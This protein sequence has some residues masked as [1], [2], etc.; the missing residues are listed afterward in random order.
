RSPF[1]PRELV[2]RLNAVLRR[3]RGDVASSGAPVMRRGPLE[4]SMAD[5]TVRKNGQVIR[6]SSREFALLATL[7]QSTGHPLSRAQ[8]IDRAFGRD[9]EVTDRAIDVQITRLRRA[10]GERGDDTGMIRT[11]RGVGYMFCGTDD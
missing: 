11:V 1:L 7:A 2:A 5:M 10:I 4:I 9:A 8:L 3:A 6:L